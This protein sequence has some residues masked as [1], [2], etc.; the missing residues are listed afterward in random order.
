METACSFKERTYG[1]IDTLTFPKPICY[2]LILLVLILI[3]KSPFHRGII[4]YQCMG[5][6]SLCGVPQEEVRKP[7]MWCEASKSISA[8]V[9][10]IYV[11]LEIART[12]ECLY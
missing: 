2:A 11:L 5:S 7:C 9:Y 6:E 1:S 12:N 3:N 8:R 4:H 10:E